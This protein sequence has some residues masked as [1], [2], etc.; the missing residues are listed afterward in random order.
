MK[1]S[2]LWWLLRCISQSDISLQTNI[3]FEVSL[4]LS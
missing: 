3:T 1:F 4:Y 2:T